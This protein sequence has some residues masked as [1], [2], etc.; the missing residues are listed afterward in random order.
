MIPHE[1]SKQSEMLSHKTVPGAWNDGKL[2]YD[3]YLMDIY[4]HGYAFQYV[5]VWAMWL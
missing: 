2:P 4:H 1:L 5:A 3:I